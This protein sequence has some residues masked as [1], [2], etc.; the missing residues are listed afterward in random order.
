MMVRA[1]RMRHRITIQ[2]NDPTQDA[3]GEL[4][5]SWSEYATRWAR[6]VTETGVSRVRE[7]FSADQKYAEADVRFELRHIEGVTPEMRVSWDNRIYD[8]VGAVNVNH[9][10]RETHIYATERTA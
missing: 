1:G 8:I 3:S 4:D 6:A 2:Q 7:S 9:R 10:D 5:D